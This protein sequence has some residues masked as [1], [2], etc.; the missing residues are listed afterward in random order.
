[1][2]PDDS[3][4]SPIGVA[5]RV[6][7]G[8]VLGFGAGAAAFGLASAAIMSAKKLPDHNTVGLIVI[9]PILVGAGAL[10]AAAAGGYAAYRLRESA[11]ASLAIGIGA[12]AV[13][14]LLVAGVVHSLASEQKRAAGK[15]AGIAEVKAR[16]TDTFGAE[17]PRTAE[18]LPRL[19]GPLH[20]PAGRLAGWD[21]LEIS[22]AA[23][24]PGWLIALETENALADVVAYYMTV[25]PGGLDFIPGTLNWP[26]H[27]R[28]GPQESADGRETSV[29]IEWAGTLT[30]VTLRTAKVMYRA[31]PD[32]E[33]TELPEPW[34]EPREAWIEGVASL[35]APGREAYSRTL[36]SVVYPGAQ[37]L[38]AAYPI[39]VYRQAGPNCVYT[40]QDTRDQVVSFLE[41]RFAAPAREA[42][43]DYFTGFLDGRHVKISVYPA[44][45][46]VPLGGVIIHY[47]L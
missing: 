30:R 23:F 26:W 22:D 2:M 28:G 8:M 35:Q 3:S 6:L 1:M 14:A 15:Q 16:W 10:L 42:G 38:S 32:T 17:Y 27:F 43:R 18:S 5:F 13:V 21:D 40:T 20:Y 34:P 9:V 44:D 45:G 12:F 29:R 33:L 7:N 4:T 36:E 31:Q 46:P 25:L 19:L 39:D 47:S 37:L 11:G 24:S 41:S